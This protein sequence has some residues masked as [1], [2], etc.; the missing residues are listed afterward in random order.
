MGA[1]TPRP[2]L[3][4]GDGDIAIH[5]SSSWSQR[6]TA[7]VADLQGQINRL[8]SRAGTG[9]GAGLDTGCV[10]KAETH[11]RAAREALGGRGLWQRLSGRASDR[12]LANVHEV[13]VAIVRLV[14]ENELRGKLLPVLVQA[15]LHLDPGDARLQRLEQVASRSRNGK[16]TEDDRE[17]LAHTLHSAYQAEQAERAKVRSFIAIVGV[18]TAVM[19]LIAVG[20]A[21]W[22][23]TDAHGVGTSFCF[24]M[25]ADNPNA[26]PTVCPLGDKP[27]WQ[28][29]WFVEFCGMLGA[30]VAGAISL[31]EVRGT[32]GPYRVASGLLLLRLPVGALT[33]VIGIILLSGRFFPGLTALDTSTQI[34]AW[35]I[36]FGVLQ[37]PVTRAI[38]RQ[39]Q[40]LLENVRASG[41]KPDNGPGKR[42]RPGRK[43]PASSPQASCHP[44]PEPEPEPV[45]E[46]QA[47][48]QAQAESEPEPEPASEPGPK[49]RGGAV[50]RV[51]GRRS[52][53]RAR[54]RP[55]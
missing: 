19:A 37:E 52:A 5:K 15:R 3:L 1:R 42:P 29:V 18:A 34:I 43:P 2:G 16:V 45:P 24:P 28:G 31:R 4:D 40:F 47:Q 41:R 25:N 6:T 53:S 27:S 10:E 49:T 46:P 22:A 36:A 7:H 8:K 33:A 44:E 20:F 12:A 17:L 51:L 50:S 11:L 13:E 30:A 54:R 38:D 39:G 48:A 55:D 23:L 9:A 35:A 26:V 21:L 14:P 32:A